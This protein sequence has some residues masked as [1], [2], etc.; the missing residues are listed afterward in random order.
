MQIASTGK[1]KRQHHLESA[2]QVHDVKMA[3]HRLL[4]KGLTSADKAERLY[5]KKIWALLMKQ[6]NLG[7]TDVKLVF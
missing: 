4:H 5:I 6:P 2:C 7:Y 1:A 3:W